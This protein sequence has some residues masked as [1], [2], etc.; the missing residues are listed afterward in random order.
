MNFLPN[1]TVSTPTGEVVFEYRNRDEYREARQ[2]ARTRY[3][4]EIAA[5]P[6][7]CVTLTR[8]SN[9][10]LAEGDYAPTLLLTSDDP[11]YDY[12]G[13]PERWDV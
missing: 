6:L 9:V 13:F 3:Y 5:H 8:L 1:F 2:A 4:L 10:D 12:E 11:E 7:E